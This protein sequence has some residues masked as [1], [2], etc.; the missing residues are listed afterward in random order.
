M[1]LAAVEN[2][3]IE[4]TAHKG[5]CVIA[6]GLSVNETIDGK[7][8]C[9]DG[10]VVTVSGGTIPG[11]QISPVNVTIN[12]KIIKGVTVGGKLPLAVNEVSSGDEIGQYQ[13][14]ENVVSAPIVL[15]ITNAGQNYVNMT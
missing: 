11:P 8:V 13:V 3:V 15:T 14:G 12:A 2:C 4:D 5:Q 9:L 6:S 10:L 7:K 1:P